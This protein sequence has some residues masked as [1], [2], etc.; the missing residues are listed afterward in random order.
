[1]NKIVEKTRGFRYVEAEPLRG[2]GLFNPDLKLDNHFGEVMTVKNGGWNDINNPG[3]LCASYWGEHMSSKT[4]EVASRYE[5]EVEYAFLVM[6]QTGEVGVFRRP[7]G[8]SQ[9]V[10]LKKERM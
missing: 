8:R 4:T 5:N 3:G 1:L 9:W 10:L 2:E 7:R 6:L